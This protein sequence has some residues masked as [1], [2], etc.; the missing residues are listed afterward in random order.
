MLRAQDTL[1]LLKILAIRSLP[2]PET[3][4]DPWKRQS[5]L[6]MYS[7]LGTQVGISGSQAH[8]SVKRLAGSGL[9]DKNNMCIRPRAATEWLI[10]GV[11]YFLPPIFG[12]LTRGIPT[13]YA[14]PPLVGEFP[15]SVVDAEPLPVWDFAEGV[16][17]VALTPIYPTVPLAAQRDADLYESLALLDAIRSARAREVSLAVKMLTRKLGA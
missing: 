12:G 4:D 8:E 2:D 5:Y 7:V 6:L 10:H 17:G 1:V 11:K 13:S 16:R 9:V 3:N 15:S 14:A